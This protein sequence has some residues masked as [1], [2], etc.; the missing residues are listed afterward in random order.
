MLGKQ[1]YAKTHLIIISCVHVFLFHFC[2][3]FQ[4]REVEYQK[5]KLTKFLST[6]ILQHQSL[7]ELA[8]QLLW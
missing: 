6:T 1:H 2:F 5:A 8:L 7:L 3:R 4:T